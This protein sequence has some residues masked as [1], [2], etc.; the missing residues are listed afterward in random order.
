[1][2]QMGYVVIPKGLKER[3]TTNLSNGHK[4]LEWDAQHF[5]LHFAGSHRAGRRAIIIFIPGP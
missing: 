4:L 2:L 1:M 5:F 3:A